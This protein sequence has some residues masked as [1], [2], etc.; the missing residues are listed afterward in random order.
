METET[1]AF[2]LP[3]SFP[4]PLRWL[5]SD[6]INCPPKSPSGGHTW[7]WPTLLGSRPAAQRQDIFREPKNDHKN[8]KILFYPNWAKKTDSGKILTKI[9]QI[10]L[11]WGCGKKCQNSAVWNPN[12][13]QFSTILRPRLSWPGIMLCLFSGPILSCQP[14]LA[15]AK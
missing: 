15:P 6:W 12:A 4:P 7:W 3:S 10:F 1:T 14:T 8:G 11:S 5:F 13:G 9:K 2:P